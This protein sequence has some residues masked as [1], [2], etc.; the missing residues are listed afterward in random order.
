MIV[1]PD[2]YAQEVKIFLCR[3]EAGL[4]ALREWIMD[5]QAV[6]NSAWPSKEDAELTRMQGEARLLEKLVKLMDVGPS[7]KP[8]VE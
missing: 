3:H 2:Q 5:R 8:K 4:Q 1:K 7:I 6:I